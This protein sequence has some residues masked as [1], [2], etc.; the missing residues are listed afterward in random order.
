[1]PRAV[2]AS[3]NAEA[4]SAGTQ[5]LAAGGNAFDA[6]VAATFVEYV[7]A[8]GVTS[9]AGPLTALV[10]HKASGERVFL[11][12][13]LDHVADPDGMWAD[14]EPDGKGVMVPGALH[15]L[16]AI[17]QRFGRLR[18]SQLV[19]PAIALAAHGFPIDESYAGTIT[20]REGVL[21]ATPYGARTFFR[22][23]DPL[24]A[25]ERL[26]QP[27]LAQFLRQVAEDG[28][29]AMY[30]GDWG[31]R[32]VAAV[33]ARGGLMRDADLHGYRSRWRA[34][35]RVTYRGHEVYGSS[36]RSYGGAWSL[37]ALKTLERFDMSGSPHVSESAERLEVLVRIAQHLWA[38]SW[39][40]DTEHLDSDEKV[41]QFLTAAYGTQVWERVRRE[42]PALPTR[43]RGT[44][45]YHVVVVDRDGNAITGTNTIN[46]LPWG[47]GIFVD[48]IPLTTALSHAGNATRP[49]ERRLSP[50][51]S[52]LVFRDGRMRVVSGTFNASLVEAG[53]QLVVNAID[54][55]LSAQRAASAPRFGTY[56]FSDDD[57]DAGR[58]RMWLDPSV[59][60]QV[61]DALRRRGLE[62]EQGSP[63]IDT[64]SGAIAM[65]G[66]DGSVDAA[67]LP[68]V[69]HEQDEPI[70]VD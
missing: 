24:Q 3:Y 35:R 53:F 58:G 45:S 23:G 32:C 1:M 64:G 31:Q 61:T 56:S 28:S 7:V 6:F 47:D 18:W 57:L 16:E 34:P 60:T 27:E 38:E 4:R 30:H 68:L 59:S 52:H 15:G 10:H 19:Q 9:L 49:G 44:H 11:D 8:P 12:A 41:A 25:G 70:H 54:F 17:H 2:V 62:F 29:A 48:G 67:L 46:A 42:L 13:E 20:W 36:G 22:R 51:S 26:V 40:F 63:F 5:V 21:G 55:A 37:L 43:R 69:G 66:E 65:V 33:R 14:G 39:L 50:M